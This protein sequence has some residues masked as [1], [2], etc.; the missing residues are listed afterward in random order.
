MTTTETRRSLDITTGQALLILY[1]IWGGMW[2]LVLIVAMVILT[3]CGGTCNVSES[4][5]GTPAA[6]HAGNSERPGN[7]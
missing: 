1:S 5:N 2:F 6:A 7:R 4:P 3:K